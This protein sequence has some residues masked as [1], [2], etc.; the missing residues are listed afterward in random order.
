MKKFQL[1]N[2]M[3]TKLGE[4][5]LQRLLLTDRYPSPGS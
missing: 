5:G 2:W 3:P 4:L 1:I